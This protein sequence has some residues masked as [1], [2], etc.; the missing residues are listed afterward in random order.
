LRILDGI[1]GTL[2]ECIDN[3]M[4]L[5]S[6][7]PTTSTTGATGSA[8]PSAGSKEEEEPSADKGKGKEKAPDVTKSNGEEAD[9]QAVQHEVVDY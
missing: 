2:N 3:L 9:L 8:S 5:R 6:A 4:E 1:S 7:L